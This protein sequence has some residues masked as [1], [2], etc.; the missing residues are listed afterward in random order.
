MDKF[1]PETIPASQIE[2]KTAVTH[3]TLT[4]DQL[5]QTPAVHFTLLYLPH[6]VI[7]GA[8][9]CQW[10]AAVGVEVRRKIIWQQQSGTAVTEVDVVLENYDENG[11]DVYCGQRQYDA[12]CQ[13]L[14][15]RQADAYAVIRPQAVTWTAADEAARQVMMDALRSRARY[16][17]LGQGRVRDLHLVSAQITRLAAH[18]WLYPIFWGC[19]EMGDGRLPIQIDGVSGEAAMAMNNEQ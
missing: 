1:F 16:A 15:R 10:S 13:W 5:P 7:S 19:Y 6:W 14:D 8:G 2:A 3:P 9:R 4:G 17:A 18:L 12:G 11:V